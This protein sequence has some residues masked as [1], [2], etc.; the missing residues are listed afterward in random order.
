M[1][2]AELISTLAG[3]LTAALVLGY[4][5]HRVGLSPIVGYL[6]AGVVVGPYT[7]GFQADRHTAEQLAEI[8]VILLMFGVGLHFHVEDLLSVH[9]VAVPG[10]I[11]QILGAAALGTVMGT[12][13]DWPLSTAIVFGLCMSVAST[14]VL[15]RVLGEQNELHTP[16]GHTA[17]GWLVVQDIFAVFVLVLMPPLLGPTTGGSQLFGLLALAAGKIVALAAIV[18]LGGG[19]VIPW[20]LRHAAATHS[21][22]LF[23]LTVLVVAIGISVGSAELFGVSMA[24]GAFLAGMVVGRSEFSLRATTDALPM[25]DAFAVLFFV[26]VGML[27]DPGFLLRSPLLVIAALVVVMIGT[28]C[29]TCATMLLLGRPFRAALG[30]GLALAQIGEFSFILAKLGTDLE[31]LPKEA[32]HALVAAAII[33]ISVNPLLYR[34]V[35]SI[36]RWAQRRPKLWK[37][38]NARGKHSG[39]HDGPTADPERPSSYRAVV[40]GYGPVGRT[41]VRLLKENDIEPTVIEMDLDTVRRL[42]ADGIA[43]VYGDASHMETLKEAGVALAGNL[44]LS[45]SGQKNAEEVVRV[46]RVLNP[47]V[48]VVARATYLRERPELL[49]AGADAVFS[50]EGEVALA[51][52]ESLLREL[53][54]SPDQIDRERDRVRRELFG[55]TLTLLPIAPPPPPT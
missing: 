52:T 5:T 17:I 42:R 2:N 29:V 38:L 31:V 46:A 55:E 39:A 9:R 11:V 18:L 4:L 53:G 35:G 41:L 47:K 22:E 49:R 24:L 43:A 15:T 26:S 20:I 33:T 37:F 10:S 8:G 1:H 3:A 48:G 16:L 21:R 44:I 23:T 36:E 32:T 28:P 51:M 34:T 30:M 27:F 54:A 13:L 40:V 12:I 6:L 25:R 50:G 7:P 19:R 45:S 14:V